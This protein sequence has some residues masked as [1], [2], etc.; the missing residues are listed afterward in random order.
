MSWDIDYNYQK[1][2][3]TGS[4]IQPEAT[5]ECSEEVPFEVL[6]RT[7]QKPKWKVV[8]WVHTRRAD[9]INETHLINQMPSTHHWP[10][11]FTTH[12]VN[13]SEDSMSHDIIRKYNIFFGTHV[14]DDD[15]N[16]RY[17]YYGAY[18]YFFAWRTYLYGLDGDPDWERLDTFYNEAKNQGWFPRF[19]ITKSINYTYLK[20]HDDELIFY[21][22]G[23]VGLGNPESSLFLKGP[24]ANSSAKIVVASEASKSVNSSKINYREDMVF[25]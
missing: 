24:R 8:T 9:G 6:N 19:I 23:N 20:G 11:I 3:A 5:Q 7:S 13:D 2:K 21:S 15:C 12:W 17:F 14:I 10:P 16:Y 25:P 1:T 18:Y 22:D 4:L